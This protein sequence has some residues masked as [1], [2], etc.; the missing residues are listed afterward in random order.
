MKRTGLMLFVLIGI[1]MA[2]VTGDVL[3]QQKVIK[4]TYS[5]HSPPGAFSTLN[6]TEPYLKDI[7]RVSDGR[8]KIE[9]YYVES[10]AKGTD[11]WMALKTG[12]ADMAFCSQGYWPGMTPLSDVITLP[13]LPLKSG[14]QAS[15]ILWKLRD[16]YRKSGPTCSFWS[17]I[18]RL[19]LLC[20]RQK[21]RSRP[22]RTSR[23]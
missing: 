23:V 8:I 4:L 19:H 17:R 18:A 6:A 3:A 15:G 7:E 12:V 10:L 2:G 5:D 9:R 1:V 22:W 11:A 14:A 20:S 16:K 13:F 21:N